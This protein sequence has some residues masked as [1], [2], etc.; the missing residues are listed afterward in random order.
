MA[1]EL[2]TSAQ[3][4]VTAL[5]NTAEEFPAGHWKIM[6]YS[7]VPDTWVD[8]FLRHNQGDVYIGGPYVANLKECCKR[9]PDFT[10]N[11]THRSHAKI[12][13]MRNG[14]HYFAIVGSMN[15][16]PITFTEVACIMSIKDAKTIYQ[17]FDDFARPL[18]KVDMRKLEQEPLH[19]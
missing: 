18:P 19:G 7:F 1:S 10:F 2:L 15:F 3:F 12:F 11:L 17:N 13:A 6:T 16:V 5:L 4:I 9:Y 8:C 14:R